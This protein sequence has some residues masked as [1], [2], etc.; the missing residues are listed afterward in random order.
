MSE[1]VVKKCK[2]IMRLTGKEDADLQEISKEIA[3]QNEILQEVLKRVNSVAVG[4]DKEIDDA[5]HASAMLGRRKLN[6]VI[7]GVL[8]VHESLEE[9]T[10]KDRNKASQQPADPAES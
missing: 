7:R 2:K 4:L 8:S 1:Q 5:S 6:E 3:A 9:E 10:A